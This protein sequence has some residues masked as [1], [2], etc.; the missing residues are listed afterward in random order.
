MKLDY[1]I[2]G[3]GTSGLT[4]AARLTEIPSISVLVI[5]AGSYHEPAPEIDIPGMVGRTIANPKYDWTFLSVPQK[6]AN[7][8]VI[9]HPRGK[10]LGGSSLIHFNSSCRPSKAEFDAVEGLGNEG[11]GWASMLNYMKKSET[12]VPPTGLTDE[13]A[14]VYAVAPV[15]N[16]HGSEGP[17]FKSMR[18]L[19]TNAHA[20]FFDAAESL[21]IPRNPE[22]GNGVNV[23]CLSPFSSVDP[24][25]ATRSSAVT[26]YLNPNIGR[27]NLYVLTDTQVVKIILAEDD[28]SLQKAAGV[29]VM[30][31]GV[32]SRIDGVHRDIIISAGS[33]QTPHILELS[34]IGNPEILR[35][36][37]I[38]DIID[39]PGVG[40]NLQDHISVF[41]V[42]E[43]D[44][45]ED[46]FDVV[47]DPVEL[48]KHETLYK[49][50]RGHLSYGPAAAFLFA[51]AK[52]LGA[53]DTINSWEDHARAKYTDSLA[54][55]VPSLRT[56]L[57]K[58][59]KFQE[60][61]ISD[62]NQAQAEILQF[63][64]HPMVPNSVAVPGKRYTALLSVLMHPLS[65]GS[66]HVTSSDPLT[67]PAIDPNYLSNEADLD[68]LTHIVKYVQGLFKTKPLSDL[69][70]SQILPPRDVLEDDTKLREYIKDQCTTV[71]HPLG[72]SSMLPRED[73]GVVDKKLRVYGTG[74]LRVVDLSVIPLELSCH[75]QSVAYAIGE[76]A[77][78]MIKSESHGV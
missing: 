28:Q 29:D 2:V 64:A 70:K 50:Q 39:L 42:A 13:Q 6:H 15:P 77:A 48:K 73:G 36:N 69:V 76:K 62:S 63:I 52:Q 53:S 10:G 71:F 49:E 7:N 40:E 72:T 31:G 45:S 34:G 11:W 33:I 68:M 12:T 3:G 16:A 57:E 35:R 43:I 78:D 5:E 60:K 26:A 20:K 17:V 21:G 51:S 74:N 59:Y 61:F 18:T 47:F 44:S 55:A 4:L 8:R 19:W 75:T 38:R 65:R 25:T 23:G 9:L 56:G 54:K 22:S 1:I 46:T 30:Q 14:K 66:V 32:L 24:R 41:S 37:N 58:Q 67:P 27:N